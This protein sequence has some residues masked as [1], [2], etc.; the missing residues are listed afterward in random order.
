M[1][2]N[3]SSIISEKE[4]LESNKIQHLNHILKSLNSR[5]NRLSVAFILFSTSEQRNR[6]L[7]KYETWLIQKLFLKLCT[8]FSH[9]SI[10]DQHITVEAVPAPEDINWTNLENP[11][12]RTK[13]IRFFSFFVCF[14]LIGFSISSELIVFNNLDKG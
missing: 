5:N 9:C 7:Q 2:S 1:S 14:V 8:S 10:H 3:Q 12:L 13:L 6:A 4:N 11:Y